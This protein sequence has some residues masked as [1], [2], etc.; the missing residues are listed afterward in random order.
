[1]VR[2]HN[3]NGNRVQFSSNSFKPF[4]DQEVGS[5]SI[6]VQGYV[7]ELKEEVVHKDPEVYVQVH[8]NDP[9]MKGVNNYDPWE[10]YG[11]NR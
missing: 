8:P 9:H 3:I 6:L 10:N 11:N 5:Y 1:M 4:V 7:T 2:Y